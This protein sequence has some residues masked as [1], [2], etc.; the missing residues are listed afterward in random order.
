MTEPIDPDHEAPPPPPPMG[1]VTTQFARVDPGPSQ[2]FGAI[3]F[4]VTL[5]GA[6]VVVLA[7]TAVDWTRGTSSSFSDIHTVL[8]HADEV[9][10]ISPEA[11][12]KAYFGFLG[13]ALLAATVLCALLAAV[14]A[15]G[16]PFRILAPVLAVSAIVLTF[17]AIKLFKNNAAAG[18]VRDYSDY[19]KDSRAGFYLAVG[20]FLLIGIGAAIG[21]GRD[22]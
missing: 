6:F 11:V 10:G 7:F 4:L 5:I 1:P 13:W 22:R 18:L 20:G 16:S 15:I 2:K 17:L 9:F 14:P 19:L 21:P 3:S 12:A 8:D